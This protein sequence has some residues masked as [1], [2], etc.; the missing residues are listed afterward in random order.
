MRPFFVILLSPGLHASPRLRER[1]EP[2]G[3]Q[4]LLPEPGVERLDISVVG[5]RRRPRE[6]QLDLVEEGPLVQH[7]AR[8]FGPVVA[9]DRLRQPA[10]AEERV[11]YLD[12]VE[13]AESGARLDRQALPAVTVDDREDAERTAVEEPVRHEVHRPRLVRFANPGP[14]SAVAAARVPARGI[15][16]DHRSL[17]PCY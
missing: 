5:G 13:R 2:R 17:L 15:Y 12:D 16:P 7:S 14:P 10:L 1:G 11:Q 8:K 6:V 4:Q 9:A 3:V